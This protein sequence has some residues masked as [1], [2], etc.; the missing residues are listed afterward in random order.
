M[1]S[2][3]S[4]LTRGGAFLLSEEDLQQT[5]IP[6]EFSE[7]QKQ[8]AQLCEEFVEK[9]I[10]PILDRID[11][12]D[13][14]QLMPQLLRKSAE[15]GLLGLQV[16]EEY[17]GLGVDFLTGMLFTEKMGPTHSFAVALLAH[18]GIGTLPILYFGTPEQ[19]AK[20]LPKLAKGELFAAYCLTEPGSGSDALSARTKATL[21]EDG[22]YYILNGQKMWITNGGFADLF[23]VF[24]KIDGEKFTAFLVDAKSPGVSL[25]AEEKK[26]GIK[27]S[28]TRQVFFQD[29]KVPV[30]NILGEIGRGHVIAFNILNIGRLKLAAATTGSCKRLVELSTRYAKERHQF[31]RP[32]ASFGAIQHKLAQMA[33]YTFASESSVY[34]ASAHIQNYEN[35]LLQSGQPYEKALLGA[36]QEFAAECAL[37]KVFGSEALDYVVDEAMQIY[38]GYGYSAEY[39][40]ERAYRDSRINRIYEGTNEINRMLSID[41]LLRKALKGELDLMS[42]ALQ[43]QSE[44]M[45]LPPLEEENGTYLAAEKKALQNLKKAFLAIVGYAAQKYQKALEEEQELLILAA[46]I[47]TDIYVAESMLLRTQKLAQMSHATTDFAHACT[48]VYLHDAIE[49]AGQKGREAIHHMAQGDEARMLQV[50]LKRFTKPLP[51]DTIALRRQI[52]QHLL[53]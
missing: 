48:Q 10:Y 53:K 21:S 7:E 13:P 16:P 25:G 36:A 11:T 30:E 51:I 2:T 6:E 20:Y 35:Y 45:S 22:K 34:R 8:I 44:L 46:D 37:L 31:Q 9:E 29:V 26:M 52:A 12:E 18:T 14:T 39:P 38:G 47:L 27:G 19:K 4:T 40:I 3:T 15:V 50:G 33:I 42:A 17:G 49:R 28:S 24:A 1:S 41:Y 23:T 32:I 5:F 43:V